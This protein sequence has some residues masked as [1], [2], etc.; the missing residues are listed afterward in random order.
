MMKSVISEN[1]LTIEIGLQ[2]FTEALFPFLKQGQKQVF[3]E[4]RKIRLRK[5]KIGNKFKDNYKI[6]NEP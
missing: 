4:G 3:P 1:V 6:S 5:A 2:L